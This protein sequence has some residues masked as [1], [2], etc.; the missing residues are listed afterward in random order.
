MK[1]ITLKSNGIGRYEDVSPFIITNNALEL[2]VELPN[3]CGEFFLVFQNNSKTE[4]MLLPRGGMIT[5]KELTAGELCA[6]IKHYLKGELIKTYKIESLLLKEADGS[7]VAEPE[8]A[9]LT[10]EN[11]R[12]AGLFAEEQERAKKRENSLNKTICALVRFAYTDYCDNVY[13]GGGTIEEFLS[14]FGFEL[15]EEQRQEIFGGVEH[16]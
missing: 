1:T 3:V 15:T 14:D 11:A 6:E 9:A 12:L 4:T 7:I 13:L 10:R 5:L 2:I 16:D 8:I